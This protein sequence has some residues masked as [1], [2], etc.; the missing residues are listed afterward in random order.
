MEKKFIER[1]WNENIEG[2]LDEEGFFITPN[3]SFWD[4]DY[5]NLIEMDL[6]SME[7]ITMIMEYTSQEKDG[8]K[9][10]IVM[11]VKKKMMNLIMN[12]MLI[13]MIKELIIMIIIV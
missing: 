10:I 8:T 1:E 12:M 11:K 13:Q 5:V 7:D 9:K 3:G 2:E 4:P 6:I